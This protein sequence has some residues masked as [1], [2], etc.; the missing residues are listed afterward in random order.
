MMAGASLL[1][2]LVAGI[3]DASAAQLGGGVGVPAANYTVD[4]AAMAAQQAAAAAQQGQSAM[5]RSIEAIQAMQ[6]AQAAARAAAAAAQRSATMPQVV[7]PNGLGAGGLQ[8]APG[9]TWSGASTPVQS[10]GGNGTT[11]TIN[12]TAPQAILNWQT[13]NVGAQT[14]VNFNQLASTWTALNRVTGNAGPSQILGQ[15]NAPGQVLVINQNG[16]IFGG[17]SQ[18]NVGSLIA[19][20][21]NTADQQFLTKG[22][23]SP[24][25]GTTYLPSFT[26]AGGKIIVESGAL[27]TTSA[28]SSVTSAGGFVA[29]LGAEVRNAGTIS[30]PKGQ[31]LLAAGDDFVLRPG[32]GTA[33]NVYSTTRGNE[34]APLL[35]AG[36][37]SG[38]VRNNGLILSQQGDITL[39]G[40]GVLQ[41][42]VLVSTTSVNQRGTIHLLNS[43]SDVAGGVTLT[44]NSLS[45]ILPELESPATALNSQRDA[46][47]AAAG[48]NLF[49]TGV[50]DN[51]S[52]LAD[53]PDLSRIEIVAGGLVNFQSGSLTMAQGGQVAVSAGKRVFTE[54]GATVDVSGVRNVMLPMS[55]NA[56]KLNIQGTELRDSPQNRDSG[57]LFNKNVWIDARSLTLVPAGTGGYASDRYYTKGGLLEVGGYLGNTAHTI[58]EWTAVGGT[59]TLAAPEVVTQRGSVFNISGGS[60]SYQGGFMPQTFV[61]GS[62]GR[63]YDI[64]NAPADL[65]YSAVVTG[66][67]VQHKQGGRVDPKLTEIYASPLGRGPVRWEDGY[68]VGRDAGRLIL[69]TPTSV[70]EGQIVADV[71]TGQRQSERRPANVSDGYK[72][73]QGVVARAGALALGQYTADGLVDGYGSDVKFGAP[74]PVTAGLG[75]IDALPTVRTNTVWFDAAQLSGFQLG[76]ISVAS[77][78]S[79][80]ID[81]PL[82][83]GKGGQA[84]FIAPVVEIGGNIMAQ[85]GS[86]SVSNI[87]RSDLS[88][89]PPVALVSAGRSQL[90]LREGVTIDVR[91][92]WSNR[93]LDPASGGEVAYADGGSVT[94]E[95]TQGVLIGDGSVIDVSSGGGLL[96]S[97]KTVSGKGGNVTLIAGT[98]LGTATNSGRLVL[99]G[100]LRGYGL[101]GGGTL[102]V[103]TGSVLV[104]AAG[105]PVAAT[106][107]LLRP[108]L[109][110]RGFATYD[111]NGYDRLAVANG[112]T[113][114]VTVPVLRVVEGAFAVPTGADPARALA[115]WTPPLYLENPVSGVMTPRT[116][117]SLKLRSERMGR[118]GALDIGTG[119]TISVDPGQTIALRGGSQI[120]VDGHLNAFGG[121]ISITEARASLD[122]FENQPHSRSIWIGDNAVFDVAGRNWTATDV[123]GRRY[124]VVQAGGRIEIGG[125][126]NWEVDKT[127]DQRAPDLHLII[128]PGA[129]LDAS[130]TSA[131]LDLPGLTRNSPYRPVTVATDGGTI[132]LKSAISLHLD[133]TMRAASGGQGAAGGTLAVALGGA[134]YWA[135]GALASVMVPRVLTLS[136]TQG[137]S[138]LA[139]G[140]VAG[141]ADPALT[142]GS[143]RLGVDRIMA[144]GF[145]NL[146]LFANARADGDLTLTMGQ[147][148]RLWRGIS[149][150]PGAAAGRTISLA[151]PRLVLGGAAYTKLPGSDYYTE[152]Y[153]PIRVDGRSDRLVATADLIEVRDAVEFVGFDD[154]RLTSRGDLRFL[155]QTYTSTG[156]DQ[157]YLVAPKVLTVTAAQIYPATGAAGF[158]G[159]GSLKSNSFAVSPA[160]QLII[161][162]HGGAAPAQPYSVGGGLQL[163][164]ANIE[165]GGVVR[166]PLGSIQFG[167]DIDTTPKIRFR[168]GSLTSVSGAGLVM[169][170][171]GTVDGITYLYNG[172]PIKIPAAGGTSIA[173]AKQIEINAQSVT[174][175]SGAVLDLSGGG[176]L[177]GAGFVSGRGGSV[178]VLRTALVNANPS[179]TFSQAG[180]EVYA[181]VPGQRGS[182]APVDPDSGAGAP[183]VGRQV[184][185]ADGVPGLPAGT[186]TLMPST[187]A[188]L[189]G[190]FRVEIG[191]GSAP[192][193]SGT[194]QTGSG[195]FV[196]PGYLGVANTAIMAT[197]AKALLITPADV[198]RR[199]SGYNET[200]YN[201]FLLA[202]AALRAVARPMLTIDARSL[203][204]RFGAGAGMGT[205]PALTFNGSTLFAPEAGS[206]GA[207]GTLVVVT[208]SQ[209]TGIEILGNKGQ[210][211]VSGAKGVVLFADQLN[212]LAPGRMLVGGTLEVNG[213][214][215][216]IWASTRA[217]I[218]RGG[219]TLSAAE[220][221]LA[222]GAG[223]RGIVV[224]SG[225]TI[226]TIGKGKPG[227][228]SSDGYLFSPVG[229]AFVV[230]NGWSN[231][232]A[233][234]SV[235]SGQV[236][237]DIGGCVSLCSGATRIV[238]EGT[239]AAATTSGFTL[240]DTVSYGT[241]NLVL[242]V[243]AVN[244]GSTAALAEAGASGHLPPGMAL[245]QDVLGGLLKGNTAIG[246]PALET[247]MLNAKESVNVYG[248]VVLDT[249]DASGRSRL[250]R[251]VF[252]AP[253]I[254]G[255]GTAADAVTI[256]TNEFVW[257]GTVARS[258]QSNRPADLDPLA[259]GAAMLDRLGDSTLNIIADTIRLDYAPYTR[260]VTQV[261]ANR[262]ALGFAAVN[263]TAGT[264][265]TA[266]GKGSLNVYRDQ[267]GYVTGQGWQYSGGD[268][269]INTPLLNGRGGAVLAVNA[270]GA[271][272]IRGAG[273]TPAASNV[274]GAELRFNGD[275]IRLD[276]AV[277]LPSGKLTLEAT[278][279]VV[280]GDAAR[281]DLAGREITLFD[282][283]R[284]SWGGDLV[285]TSR[286]GDIRAA[287]GSVIDLSARNNHGGTLA[288]TALG[289]QAGR[290]ALLGT[291][292]GKATGNYDAGG[293]IVPYLGAELTLRAQRLDDFAAL[294]ARL[295]DGEVFGARR[296]Q[297]KQGSLAVGDEVRARE[298]QIVVDGGDL[299][300]N[301]RLDA[302]GYQVGAIRLAAKGNLTI[303]GMLDAHGRGLRVDSYGRIIESPNRAMIELTSSEGRLVLGAQASFDLRAGTESRLADGK[304]RGTLDLI[305]SRVGANDVAV[306]VLGAV[307]IKGARTVAV[308][309][310]RAYEPPLATVPDVTGTRPQ[311][312]TQGY[313]D[314]IDLDSQAFMNAAL[315]NAA[316]SSRLAGL[317]AYHL[318]PGVEIVGK[319]SADNPK[320]SLTVVGDI[321]LSGYRY[322][323]GADRINP[324]RRGFGEPGM[325]ILRAAGDLSIHGSINDG[326]APPPDTPDD[327]GWYLNES[328][329]NLGDG[330]TPFAGDIVMP[331][332]GV[333]LEPGTV[334]AAGVKLNYD[335]PVQA[336]TLPAGTTLPVQVTLTAAL[337]L[338]AG[339][340]L[341]ADVVT[342]DGVLYKAGTVLPQ[343]LTLAANSKLGAG[344]QL[345]DAAAVAALVWPKGEK[346]PAYM[347]T[348]QRVTLARGSLIPSMTKV[349]LENHQ[350]VN[351]RPVGPDG[352]QGRNWA[353]APMLG[354]GATSWDL[355][356]VA[357]ADLG[358]SDKRARNALGTGDIVLADTHYGSIGKVTTR[359]EGGGGGTGPFVFTK[360]AALV[361]FEDEKYAGLTEAEMDVLFLTD[362]NF[363]MT[364][365]EMFGRSL[366][367]FCAGST[368]CVRKPD[369]ILNMDG[370]MGFFGDAKYANLNEAQLNALVLAD[371]QTDLTTFLGQKF[372][373]FC[374][375]NAS[376]CGV[377]GA[378]PPK[379]IKEYAFGEGASNFSVLRTGTGN[380]NLGAGR[381]VRMMSMFGVYTAGTQTSL[382]GRDNTPFNL[383]RGQ[384]G[385]YVLGD[386][387]GSG[388]YDAA[389]ANWRPWYPDLGGNLTVS[390]GRDIIGDSLGE[391]AQNSVRYPDQ[392]QAKVSSSWVGSWL[393][394]QGSGD[395]PGMDPVATSWWINFGAY[396][397]NDYTQSKQPRIVGFT[398]FGTLGG[399]DVT[400]NAG[401]HAGLVDERGGALR[402]GT[403][404]ARSEGLVVAVG[405]TGRVAGGDLILTGGGDLTLRTGDA[406]NP[407]ALA[408][409]Q[410]GG[411]GGIGRSTS[412][413]L[414]LNGVL[415]NLR[416]T[417]H[418][419]TSALG[420]MMRRYVV[421]D[422][423]LRP[424]SLLAD[425]ATPAM[426]G[427]VLMLG[428]ATAW[429]DTRGDLVL[430]G[431]GDPGR[432]FQ[433]NS[434]PY[435]RSGQAPTTGG[436]DGWFSLWTPSTAVNLFS[437]GG[438]LTPMTVGGAMWTGRNLSAEYLG[439]MARSVYVYPSILR[440]VAASGDIRIGQNI[441]T[442][443]SL[444]WT[445]LTLAPSATGQLEVLARGSILGG[446]G[447]HDFIQSGADT[448][449]PSPLRPAF[450]AWD[451]SDNFLFGNVS[452]TGV[453]ATRASD[454]L[455]A[456]GPNT[457]LSTALHGADP[458]PARFYAV[459]GSIVGLSFGSVTT[460]TDAPYKV[461]RTLKTWYEGATA[462][463]V[464]AGQDILETKLFAVNNSPLDVSLVQAGRDI[465]HADV[466]VA[467]PGLLEIAAGRHLRQEDV[468]NV[469]TLGSII[470][471]DNRSGASV[472][473]S[474]GAGGAQ[475][476]AVRN[477]YLDIVNLADP[478]RPLAS[479]PG[480]AVKLYTAELAA[481]LK[482]RFGVEGS[483]AENL[484][485]FDALPADQQR[486]F[487][488]Q[489]YYTE[490]RDGG[491]EYND[492]ASPRFN[493]YLRGREAIATLFPETTAGD[494]V[495]FGKA[496]VHTDFGGDVQMMAPGG[497]IVIG[498]EGVVPPATAGVVT[499][500]RGGIG[501]YA[502]GSILL[503]LSRIMTTFGGDILAWSA[504][505]DINAGRGSK[506][507]QVFTPS[508]R[509]TDLY[510][511]ITLSPQ[512]PATGAGI[513]TLPF[514]E[515]PPGDVDL[516]APLGT[517]DAGEA[518]IRYSGNINVAALQIVNAAN[519]TGQGT[520]TGIP[521]V[522][523][524]PSL[525][526]T[527]AANT[528]AATQQA[529]P[530]PARN[531]SQS[532]IIMVEVL[533]YGGGADDKEREAPRATRER[534]SSYDP[535]GVLR[536]LGNGTF[537]PE[538]TQQL[539]A[540]ERSKLAGTVN[541]GVA[542]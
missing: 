507:T 310:L 143:G 267:N 388:G 384:F 438:D 115:L 149:L 396:A 503:G 260:P 282:V 117:A 50:F 88:T 437:A 141:A 68:T 175:D 299:T 288:A 136:Q 272:D 108:D 207:A 77:R 163:W 120:T 479:Q 133:G 442:G 496:G 399:G 37:S 455:F 71:I 362:P 273:G 340:V 34:V 155:Q 218:V 360:E 343:A 226:S 188:L 446:A 196:T 6:G 530:P 290:V 90:T 212:A 220:V 52:K 177:T 280:L 401:R 116:G 540:E 393:W 266:G 291:V 198:T 403:F 235:E 523:G 416:G 407:N 381:D 227:F 168:D 173:T 4:A 166:A 337:S 367:K 460:M 111:I 261:P 470:A 298:I 485:T 26:G 537:S 477:R 84:N 237:I 332:G 69:S 448:A 89:I 233:P 484:A 189:P 246:A 195:S 492:P 482:E 465:I 383:P 434:S 232:L 524:P 526:L 333:N 535:N 191:K 518:G 252:G 66:F 514:P 241:K 515:V 93:G 217:V 308:Y 506:T 183:A 422:G 352:R 85:S 79:I 106:Q 162:S 122:T 160:G 347:T 528:T 529:V 339:L 435:T 300:V 244:L 57:A 463:R 56:I 27:L 240:R 30:T 224:E 31:A 505:G 348:S 127:I 10:A 453:E 411:S 206:G 140:L 114:D 304:A 61:L 170:Y 264:A 296:F 134:Y 222:A 386:I 87:L 491:R 385:Q 443:D 60:L 510:G 375:S 59:I 110:R 408:S 390:A 121:V 48:L 270:G 13:F 142:F 107:T 53:R 228:D 49:A 98:P 395:T 192:Y 469:R 335:V 380:L 430:G 509:I 269:T 190:A 263:L 392:S 19:S 357:G 424:D 147:S 211:P 16:I 325:L 419:S 459:D 499:Q 2:L 215:A 21:A 445:S 439:Q 405:S 471:G 371:Y 474:A 131:V 40:R 345:R 97:G 400:I 123:H 361:W 323:P 289:E 475:W 63:V 174:V 406:F 423:G 135:K 331:I 317:G 281:I 483:A 154:V 204:F 12:Q 58:G 344:F 285:L 46:M 223:G 72:L 193:L 306:D 525:A 80:V 186:Y 447:R 229:A 378:E 70:F 283:R 489:V 112:T 51:L 41:D 219:A 426:G 105:T 161:A 14:T 167:S 179:F 139:A 74:A 508:K 516:I 468:A 421:D 45:L 254:Y 76:G 487:L 15:I 256:R 379:E 294:N 364:F 94:F 78:K 328:R 159:V 118:G 410:N 346:L 466:T 542:P 258:S 95:S 176:N 500:G 44:G 327:K 200:G 420:I 316:L 309:G 444:Q 171:G 201:D 311:E 377:R 157:S 409:Q 338:P 358:S 301:G 349:V 415:V 436:G 249:F 153:D 216:A 245:N 255:Y 203:K 113:I 148:L 286:T 9:G 208:D 450:A 373:D 35:Q 440:A 330:L 146:S 476:Q 62:D 303:N 376:F 517:I 145:D 42:G 158:L 432:V 23:Y 372:A 473:L 534:S 274:L 319:V 47:I 541:S 225:A 334:F 5:R 495:M 239:I 172:Q 99:D 180:S 538:Q 320:G 124:G 387:Q 259:P 478:D 354:E 130:G 359:Y 100:E 531:D 472:V 292:R 75:A 234:S 302:S 315:G 521:T 493:S 451:K 202:D 209:A 25:S 355:T 103:E 305:A 287:A 184:T 314:A 55:S 101:G 7:V 129:V 389:L 329:D 230:S 512:A 199:H 368:Y 181:I 102:K 28:P 82:V 251:L 210:A 532:S 20:A 178:D 397:V 307:D 480:K 22:I 464:L 366:E 382:A 457:I 425:L 504:E 185:I 3:S 150:T 312:I 242:G 277:V 404:A 43:A 313:L 295:N 511:R 402:G 322:G 414:D 86:V 350:P 36:S 363:G 144:G 428:D 29:L 461:T 293:T 38:L 369:V 486:I 318:R 151:A 214:T 250:Q 17:A 165:Q 96:P 429:L 519:I 452:V 138:D 520:A 33:A 18:I 126:L 297:L 194:G 456:F 164:A 275:T 431:V 365:V 454:T 467:G 182:Y 449:L 253:A 128:R 221:I 413:N 533:G 213:D 351:L 109:F 539:T 92:R 536:V 370:A 125:A 205:T 276:T 481:W 257:A 527:A 324:A 341:G 169:P 441:A 427:P 458:T 418:L 391:D 522:Q 497:R 262:L 152:T 236:T 39:A 490:L 279:D 342:A 1:T 394:R 247:L 494:I 238:S 73:P 81:A 197:Q 119:S 417:L 8:V 54:N 433:L 498:V 501:L 353:L 462:A 248:S 284:Y 156:R 187:Y 412:D 374:R 321:D 65:A 11:V 32:Y 64:N 336:L 137:A 513:A 67:M 488:R 91:G 356:A 278:R 243:S 271:I 265:I 83:L 104:A 502:R 231:L 132:V 398:G 268:L 24:Q 326:F